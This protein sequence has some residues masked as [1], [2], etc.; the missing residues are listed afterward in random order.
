MKKITSKITIFLMAI[1]SPTLSFALPFALPHPTVSSILSRVPDSLSRHL[2]SLAPDLHLFI[3]GG[4][5][6]IGLFLLGS[7]L[8]KIYKILDSNGQ[9]SDGFAAPIFGLIG[10]VILLG[11][12][13]SLDIFSNSFVGQSFSWQSPTTIPTTATPAQL[14][15]TAAIVYMQIIGVIMFI[16]GIKGYS[17]ISSGGHDGASPSKSTFNV[18][19]GVLLANVLWFTDAVAWLMGAPVNSLRAISLF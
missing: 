10:G 5:A 16:L 3:L 9:S 4:A 6:L 11:M 1:L 12:L 7:S 2:L 14:A 18:I 17:A 19:G 15:G 13:T 8:M